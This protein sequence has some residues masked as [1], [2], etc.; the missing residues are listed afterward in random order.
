MAFYT[1]LGKLPEKKHC[2]FYKED[3][4]SLYR[5]ELFSTKGFSGIY[6]LRYHEHMPTE[7]LSI[8]T[9]SVQEPKLEKDSALSWR[10]FHT[11]RDNSKGDGIKNRRLWLRNEDC[12]IYTAHVT[13]QAMYGY[14]NAIAHELVFVHRGSGFLYSDF[15]MIQF[16]AGDYLVI[17]KGCI[18]RLVFDHLSDNRLLLVESKTPFEIPSKYRNEFGQLQ[19]HAPYS[20]RDFRTP[21]ELCSHEH[22]PS[23]SIVCKAGDVWMLQEYKHNPFDVVGWEGYEYP[24]AFNIKDFSPVVGKIHLP[25]PVHQVF[26]TQSFVVC[27]FVP[28]LFDFHEHAVPAPYFHS[29]VDSDE[30]IYYVEG[31]FMSRTGIEEGSVSY[32]PMGLP[33]GPQPGKTENSIGKKETKEF[34]VMIDTFSPLQ[35]AESISKLEDKNYSRSWIQK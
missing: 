34:A 18:Y 25:P 29:N 31:D 27:N 19:E 22:L 10:L 3:G 35:K 23:Q 16:A 6:S 21:S 32:H 15:G 14:K 8:T 12:S 13:D 30:V 7:I 24:Y 20:E 4:V 33:H 2:T 5:E 9:Q 17:P 1:R 28:R 11:H 26:S